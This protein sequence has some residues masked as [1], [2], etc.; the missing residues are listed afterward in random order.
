MS[1]ETIQKFSEKFKDR[2]T[3]HIKK[4]GVDKWT[5]KK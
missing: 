5:S 4:V 3:I 2:V 1:E